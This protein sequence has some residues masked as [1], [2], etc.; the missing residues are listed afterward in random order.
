MFRIPQQNRGRESNPPALPGF[1]IDSTDVDSMD[2]LFT[3]RQTAFS[4]WNWCKYVAS[5]LHRLWSDH[6]NLLLEDEDS[7]Q[8]LKLVKEGRP[9]HF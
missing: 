6:V 7:D 9:T 3:E 8:L 2:A 1:M 4:C 5:G